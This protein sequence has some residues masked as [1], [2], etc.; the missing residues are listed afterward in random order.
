MDS[1]AQNGMLFTHEKEGNPAI[2]DHMGGPWR[3]YAKICA[4]IL[5]FIPIIKYTLW[6]TSWKL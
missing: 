3:H 1:H 2:F 6:Y 4:F 5:N